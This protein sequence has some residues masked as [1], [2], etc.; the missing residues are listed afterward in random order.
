MENAA[1]NS[2]ESSSRRLGNRLIDGFSS[3]DRNAMKAGERREEYFGEYSNDRAIDPLRLEPANI[4]QYGFV[5]IEDPDAPGGTAQCDWTSTVSGGR[6][7]RGGS[8]QTNWRFCRS[9]SR[10]WGEQFNRDGVAGVRLALIAED[11][12]SRSPASL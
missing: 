10:G 9:A 11:S 8:W 1:P 5:E 7:C 4:D 3:F 6:V 12:R 2:K